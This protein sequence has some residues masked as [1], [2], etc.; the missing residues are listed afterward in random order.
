MQAC[1][2]TKKRLRHRCFY[3]SFI[4]LLRTPISQTPCEKLLL[5]SFKIP[6]VGFIFNKFADLQSAVLTKHE[7]LHTL[8]VFFKDFAHF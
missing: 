2:F 5:K 1:N 8:E 7:L 3:L 4:N 6:F